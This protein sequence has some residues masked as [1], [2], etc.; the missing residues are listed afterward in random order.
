MKK[1]EVR[2]NKNQI[3]NESNNININ[4]KI[5][6]NIS[7]KIFELLKKFLKWFI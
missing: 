1:I 7:T 6:K 5:E 4:N 3:I 2:G